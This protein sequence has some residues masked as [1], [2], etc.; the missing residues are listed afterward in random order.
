M[1]NSYRIILKIFCLICFFYPISSV[2]FFNCTTD[3]NLSTIG[4]PV[5]IAYNPINNYLI[6]ALTNSIHLYNLKTNA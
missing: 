1:K 2:D 5:S 3:I 6:I 4:T